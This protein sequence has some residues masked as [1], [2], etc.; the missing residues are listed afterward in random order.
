M[1]RT[2]IIDTFGNPE[3]LSYMEVGY[4]PLAI[5][6][7]LLFGMFMVLA[8]ILNGFRKLKGGVLVGNNSLAISAACHRSMRDVGAELRPVRFG[9]LHHQLPN[10]APGHVCFSSEDVEPPRVGELYI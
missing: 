5:L 10:G 1:A 4:S 7:A 2:E 8:M 6:L 9:A 3:P